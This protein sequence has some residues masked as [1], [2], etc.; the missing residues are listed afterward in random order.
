MPYDLRVAR[1]PRLTGVALSALA[2]AA[3]NPVTM[4]VL[5]PK[6]L[7]DSGIAAL[8]EARVD[9]PPSVLPPLPRPST[10]HAAAPPPEVDLFVLAAAPRAGTGFAFESTTDYARAFREG[11]TTPAE[12]ADRLVDALRRADNLDP[13]LHAITAWRADQL[14]EQ[15]AASTERW[16]SGKPLS[17]L[18]G[19]PIAVKEELD[20]AGY[21]TTSGTSYLRDVAAADAAVVARL[22]AAGALIYGKANMIE[23]GIDT[24]GFNAH[25][26]TARNPYGRGN[27]H[28]YAGGSSTGS[29]VAVAA[30]LG[31]IAVGADGGGSV[32]IPS[33]L[34]GVVGLKATHSRISE[35]GVFPLCWSV[36]HV[37]PIGATVRDVALAYA[38]MAGPVADDPMSLAQPAPS[39]EGVDGGARVEGVRLG[40]YRPWFEDADPGVVAVCRAALDGLVAGGAKLVEVDIP[41]LELARIAHIVTIFGE[42]ATTMDRYAE[43]RREQSAAVRINLAL[44]RTLTARDYVQAQRARTRVAAHF[45]RAFELCDALVTPTT[46]MTAPEVRRDV[47]PRGESNLEVTSAL[48]RFVFPQNLTGHPALSVPCGYDAQG[49]PVGLQLT[50]RP[51]EEHLLLR[52]AEA[53]E[54]RLV[55]RKPELWLGPLLS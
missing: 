48:M 26:G 43:H 55:R 47:F 39:L 16:R 11:K 35:K 1:V 28:R 53:V 9:E 22:R 49:L 14:K 10:L 51:W 33:A 34:C 46:A 29:G 8:R 21:P 50:G 36:G 37:G 38:V 27:E 32:R 54:H 45:A 30:G 5:A 44:A 19:V 13:P 20:V 12:V 52:V 7:K 42:M 17:P 41:E 23:L 4:S 25:H 2:T 31:P 3:D 40:V 15:A 24:L 6:L 18:D